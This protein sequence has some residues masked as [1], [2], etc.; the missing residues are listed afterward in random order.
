MAEKLS[1]WQSAAA[2]GGQKLRKAET[3]R[4][5]GPAQQGVTNVAPKH[6]LYTGSH[7]MSQYTE[8]GLPLMA[9]I[10]TLSHTRDERRT[11]ANTTGG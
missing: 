10:S 1:V 11:D 9:K 7:A 2:F 5:R 3:N 6:Q 4:H 8:F